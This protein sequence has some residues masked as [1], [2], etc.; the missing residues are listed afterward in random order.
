MTLMIALIQ[1]NTSDVWG[2]EHKSTWQY[3]CQLNNNLHAVVNSWALRLRQNSIYLPLAALAE[4]AEVTACIWLD[5]WECRS[6]NTVTHRWDR[7]RSIWVLMSHDSTV[8]QE[9]GCKRDREGE[10]L[11]RCGNVDRVYAV[12]PPPDMQECLPSFLWATL[13]FHIFCSIVGHGIIYVTLHME[14]NDVSTVKHVLL[15][16]IANM[17]AF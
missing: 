3:L 17:V 7:Y 16:S 11:Y 13:E 5:Q 4:Q 15:I 9:K 6:V 2:K 12:H 14:L 1:L 10:E 8:S